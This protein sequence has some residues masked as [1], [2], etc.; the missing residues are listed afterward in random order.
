MQEQLPRISIVTPSF[1]QAG[2]IEQTIKSVIDQGYT[3]LQY[4]IIDGAST[5]NTV[6]VIKKYSSKIDC[7]VS[8]KDSGQSSAINKGFKKVDGVICSWLGSDDLLEPG[9]LF[10]VAE[11]Y[12]KNPGIGVIAGR[13]KKINEAGNVIGEKGPSDFNEVNLLNRWKQY[14]P[15]VFFNRD[16][17]DKIGYLDESLHFALDT[18]YFLRI[19]FHGF[20]G[21]TTNDV[22]ASARFWS[23]CKSVAHKYI[24]YKELRTVLEKYSQFFDLSFYEKLKFRKNTLSHLLRIEAKYLMEK[25]EFEASIDRLLNSWKFSFYTPFPNIKMSVRLLL[26]YMGVI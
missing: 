8:E 6:E 26:K 13:C 12:M 5:D 24:H 20:K 22:L 23:D 16:V 7:W 9:S 2:F 11:L 1:N 15:A 3:N 19:R 4:I 25:R 10:K 18:E 17:L 21:I 14:Q